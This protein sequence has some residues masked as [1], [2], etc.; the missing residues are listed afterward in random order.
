ML[1]RSAVTAGFAL[2]LA[3]MATPAIAQTGPGGETAAPTAFAQAQTQAAA[4]AQPSP[5]LI[6]G[7]KRDLGITAEQATTR[8]INEAAAAK[9]GPAIREQLAAA[10]PGPG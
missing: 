3:L 1:R 7:M 9:V 6:E 4:A 10:S 5:A 2:A 8:L